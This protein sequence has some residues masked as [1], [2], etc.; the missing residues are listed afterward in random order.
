MPAYVVQIRRESLGS[1]GPSFESVCALADDVPTVLNL[2]RTAL[3]LDDEK[4]EVTRTL[5]EDEVH[6]LALKPFQVKRMP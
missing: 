2:V 1:G 4:L 6:G 5:R 3:R